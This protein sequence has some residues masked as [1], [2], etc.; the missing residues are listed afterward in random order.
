MKCVYLAMD[1][2]K[3]LFP[4]EDYAYQKRWSDNKYLYFMIKLISSKS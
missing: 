4:W 1:S 2:I 3:Q